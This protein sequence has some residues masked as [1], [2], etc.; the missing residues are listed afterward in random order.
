[1]I[2]SHAALTIGLVFMGLVLLSLFLFTT[3]AGMWV[4][5]RD[6]DGRMTLAELMERSVSDDDDAE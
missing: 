3:P 2:A 4:A 6:S 5:Q 1:M